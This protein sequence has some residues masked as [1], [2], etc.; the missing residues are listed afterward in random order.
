MIEFTN[1]D[2]EIPYLIFKNRYEDAKKAC[3]KNIE[4]ICISSYSK[5][6]DEVSSRYVNLKKINGK[7]FIFFSNYESPKAEDFSD[8]SKISAVFFWNNTNTQIRLKAIIKKTS[9]NFNKEYFKSRD[10]N[11]NALAISSQQSKLIDSFETVKENYNKSLLND[12]L[13]KCPDYWG[14]FSFKPYYFEF[15]QGDNSRL[16]KRD[17]YEIVK[18]EWVHHLLQP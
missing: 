6:K 11:K 10:K 17:A 18:E 14:G 1:L 5:S 4:A 9:G 7:D 13:Q 2:Q 12:D 3:Q 8:N 16:N 15:W